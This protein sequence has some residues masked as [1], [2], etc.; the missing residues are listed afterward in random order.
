MDITHRASF[1]S[2]KGRTLARCFDAICVS[3]FVSSDEMKY[4]IWKLNWQMKLAQFS[5][6]FLAFLQFFIQLLLNGWRSLELSS[7]LPPGSFSLLL[8]SYP[9][10]SPSLCSP[11]FLLLLFFLRG[12]HL[13]LWLCTD[14]KSRATR[15]MCEYLNLDLFKEGKN[16]TSETRL[17]QHWSVSCL[18]YSV[19]DFGGCWRKNTGNWSDFF[20]SQHLQL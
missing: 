14:M 9:C 6:T 16:E 3:L 17:T 8:M 20:G 18:S 19:R 2:R 15:F 13:W 11:F 4:G 7:V 12:A 10:P 5:K 1:L